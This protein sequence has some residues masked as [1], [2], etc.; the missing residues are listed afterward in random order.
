MGSSIAGLLHRI[1]ERDGRDALI[2]FIRPVLLIWSV[3]FN[4][5]NQTDQINK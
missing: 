4:Q 2:W 1:A 5:T 3:P